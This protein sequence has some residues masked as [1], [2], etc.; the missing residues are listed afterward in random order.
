MLY[1]FSDDDDAIARE[2]RRAGDDRRR[3]D[4]VDADQRAEA[5][6]QLANQVIDRR[7]ADVVRPRCRS[8]ARRRSPSW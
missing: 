1:F 5:D 7:L 3:R 4:A 8:S 6:R 2:H